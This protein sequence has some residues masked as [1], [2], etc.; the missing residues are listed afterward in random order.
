MKSLQIASP[1]M[2]T[3][4]A[5]MGWAT[6]SAAEEPVVAP[7]PAATEVRTTTSPPNF[8]LI[9]TGVGLFAVSYVPSVVVAAVNDT[10]YD[11]KLY[12]PFAG[13]WMNLGSR[14]G[15]GG[16]GQFSCGREGAYKALLIVD[17]VAQAL[18]GAAV[19][20]GIFTP[21]TRTTTVITTTGQADKMSTKLKV[22]FV[23]TEVARD[24]YGL[25]AFGTF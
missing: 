4:I 15:C 23:P 13:P 12:I 8:P 19:V 16:P 9:V 7:R 6:S 11:N 10:R 20:A 14:P 18:G 25:V 1:A 21:Q 3:V 24:A 2:A 5:A 17:G 22:R